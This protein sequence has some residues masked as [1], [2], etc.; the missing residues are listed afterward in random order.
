MRALAA[1]AALAEGSSPEAHA[2]ALA[3][4]ALARS[5]ERAPQRCAACRRGAF[6]PGI[7]LAACFYCGRGDIPGV[8]GSALNHYGDPVLPGADF[9]HC[10]P[11]PAH[12]GQEAALVGPDFPMAAFEDC[13]CFPGFEQRT[14]LSCSICPAHTVQPQYSDAD[15]AFCPAGHYHVARQYPC[16]LCDIVDEDNHERHQG[17]LANS[18]NRSLAWGVAERDCLCRRGYE[19]LA[20]S[21]TCTKCRAG[22]F[23]ADAL[24]HLCSAC[25]PD[26]YQPAEA[27]LACLACPPH[28]TTL[29]ASGA[30]A[31]QRCV[32]DPGREA[33]LVAGDGAASCPLC[34]AGKYRPARAANFEDGA[35]TACILCPADSFCPEG[36]VVPQPCAPLEVSLP[37]SA[38][39][40]DCQCSTG[41][42][43]PA[44]DAG[45]PEGPRPCEDCAHAFFSPGRTNAPCQPCP[46][47]KNT[48]APAASAIE[49]CACVP[50]HGVAAEAAPAGAPLG[51]HEPCAPCADGYFALGGRNQSCVHCGFG[52][53]T[54]PPSA[55]T[56]PAACM[57]D[58]RIGLGLETRR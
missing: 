54:D 49:H 51:P 25:A 21:N 47:H 4:A 37:G 28:S 39:P 40:I 42:G 30:P 48:S 10:V 46:A 36:S 19:R 11:C 16:V 52:A 6:K 56:A 35:P 18:L 53:V 38:A 44:P 1:L 31:L 33:L 45:A 58:A 9:R 3:A 15:C 57:C 50:G 55:A 13:K 27:A 23:H 2:A 41:R 8:G 32:C 26:A 43:R 24:D 12:S 7:G 22:S 17:R 29:N 20:E 34:A 5:A 14:A